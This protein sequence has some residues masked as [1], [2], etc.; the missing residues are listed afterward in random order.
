MNTIEITCPSCQA[1]GRIP[2]EKLTGAVKTARCR[3][4]GQT[5]SLS[6]YLPQT[7]VN[8]ASVVASQ[9]GDE[10]KGKFTPIM[11]TVPDNSGDVSFRR[12]YIIICII[13]FFL[14][15]LNISIP[16]VGSMRYT[17]Y[18][19]VDL[20]FSSDTSKLSKSD[21]ATVDT[22]KESKKSYN[23]SKSPILMV[24]SIII[25]IIAHIGLMSQ[26][27]VVLLYG[28]LWVLMHR[29]SRLLLMLSSLLAVQYA[30]LCYISGSI[31]VISLKHQADTATANAFPGLMDA[32]LST[33]NIE[34]AYGAW[35]LF[36]AGASMFYVA[37]GGR[38]SK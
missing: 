17:T 35:V 22:I 6:E 11:N 38:I 31:F 10:G 3:K 24:I 27:F 18:R 5:I 15:A 37:G 14:P 9:P 1:K 29:E 20:Y 2:K 21:K 30:P 34:P 23:I 26:I 12:F 8:E 19:M 7:M 4:C 16:F 33:V 36:I 28:I 25:M 32:M 13:C